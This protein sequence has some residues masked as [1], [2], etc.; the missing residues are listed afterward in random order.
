MST[1]INTRGMIRAKISSFPSGNDNECMTKAEIIGTNLAIVNGSYGD[2]ECPIL[3]DVQ[4]SI[5]IGYI[6]ANGEVKCLYDPAKN[7]VIDMSPLLNI[8][9]SL[10]VI[11][12]GIPV[13]S[14]A[15]KVVTF[16]EKRL[17]EQWLKVPAI[18]GWG[19]ITLDPYTGKI[20]DNLCTIKLMPTNL[21]SLFYNSDYRYSV[22]PYIG[23]SKLGELS[24]EF[25]LAP[26][27]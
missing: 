7:P 14:N 11:F 24:F 19:S 8:C 16:L 5:C 13:V 20:N 9:D 17:G 26:Q 3:D 12:I 6:G 4:L 10:Y 1:E 27:N 25:S 2:N 21:P 18:D 23:D 15:S 22:S